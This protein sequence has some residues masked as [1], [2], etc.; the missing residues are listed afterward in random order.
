MYNEKCSMSDI[1]EYLLDEE[2]CTQDDR[3]NFV[4]LLYELESE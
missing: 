3:E 1:D 4:E 2:N